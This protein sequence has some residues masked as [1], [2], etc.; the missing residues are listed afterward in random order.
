MSGRTHFLPR[1]SGETRTIIN[2]RQWKTWELSKKNYC[3]SLR[4]S[5]VGV[6]IRNRALETLLA[7]QPPSWDDLKNTKGQIDCVILENTQILNWLCFII[8][9]LGWGLKVFCSISFLLHFT[10][11]HYQGVSVPSFLRK[12][13]Y[14]IRAIWLSVTVTHRRSMSIRRHLWHICYIFSYNLRWPMSKTSST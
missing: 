6:G 4:A 10:N 2:Y 13:W 1:L 8:L 7:S 11:L 14:G 3:N 9:R 5:L 12:G